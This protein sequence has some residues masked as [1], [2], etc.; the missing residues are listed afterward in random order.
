MHVYAYMHVYA[1]KPALRPAEFGKL[2][3]GGGGER[4][5]REREG[6]RERAREEAPPRTLRGSFLKSIIGLSRRKRV[7]SEQLVTSLAQT[8]G[9]CVPL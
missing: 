2:E 3:R 4:R 1:S 7:K 8:S 5:E 9:Q 6:E